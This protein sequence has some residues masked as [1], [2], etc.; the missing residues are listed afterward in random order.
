MTKEKDEKVCAIHNVRPSV[1]VNEFM[2]KKGYTNYTNEFGVRK[3]HKA[4]KTWDFQ[5]PSKMLQD[6]VIFLKLRDQTP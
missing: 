2:D 1:L 3:D 5:E 6:F 4:D